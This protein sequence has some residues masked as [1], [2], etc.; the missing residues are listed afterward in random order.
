MKLDLFGKKEMEVIHR[1]GEWLAF[2]CGSEGK[3]RK[4]EGVVIPGSLSEPEVIE[5]IDDLFHEW[6]TP[7]H[8][9]VKVVSQ[10]PSEDE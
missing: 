7:S 5:Y 3:K 8:S 4:A 10:L 6:A 1:N 9:V 2:Y